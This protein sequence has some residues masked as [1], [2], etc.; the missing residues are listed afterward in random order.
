MTSAL[1]CGTILQLLHDLDGTRA[2]CHERAAVRPAKLA[3]D[4]FSLHCR[5]ADSVMFFDQGTSDAILH[6]STARYSRILRSVRSPRTDS[7]C[8]AILRCEPS[9]GVL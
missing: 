1:P 7:S 8:S 6:G 3:G 5:A 2:S 9:S 4:Q